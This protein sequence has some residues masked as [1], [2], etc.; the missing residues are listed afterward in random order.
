[1]KP[2]QLPH[3]KTF[4]DSTPVDRTF[5]YFVISTTT[6]VIMLLIFL[7]FPIYKLA[8]GTRV[9]RP[10]W[11]PPAVRNIDPELLESL[12]PDQRAAIAAT[13]QP[14][15]AKPDWL[16]AEK[17]GIR[18]RKFPTNPLFWVLIGSGIAWFL[19]QK[20]LGVF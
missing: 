15:A 18:R 6:L 10:V 1:M 7:L 20:R 11:A 17:T 5:Q 13:V 4:G 16:A 19:L 8:D 9:H 14:T 12:E 2:S 3:D